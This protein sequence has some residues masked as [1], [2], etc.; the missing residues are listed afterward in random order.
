VPPTSS[1][2]QLADVKRAKLDPETIEVD[3]KN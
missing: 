1:I 3:R 2:G